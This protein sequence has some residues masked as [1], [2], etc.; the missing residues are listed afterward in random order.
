V[1]SNAEAL[2]PLLDVAEAK[3]AAILLVEQGE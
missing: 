2:G 1:P 3:L